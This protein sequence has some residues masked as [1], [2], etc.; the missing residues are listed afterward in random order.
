[1]TIRE[2]THLRMMQQRVVGSDI[3][4]PK[5]MLEWMGALQ[6]QDFSMSKWA[7]GCRLPGLKE[8]DIEES[9]NKG[10]CLRTHAIRPTWHLLSPDNIKWLLKYSA[11]HI[12]NSLKSRYQKLGLTDKIFHKASSI[13]VN[14]LVEK[15]ICL[16]RELIDL[17][18]AQGIDTSM[19]KASYILMDIELK[20]LI[21][22]GP[23]SNK[24]QTYTLLASLECQEFLYSDDNSD[25]EIAKKYF[26]SRGPATVKDFAWWSGLPQRKAKAVVEKITPELDSY[27]VNGQEYWIAKT[28]VETSYVDQQ[29]FLLPAF[30]EMVVA[31]KDRS[32]IIDAEYLPRAVSRNGIIWPIVLLNGQAAGTW[33]R[34]IRKQEVMIE[35]SSFWGLSYSERNQIEEAAHQFAS[36]IDKTPRVYFL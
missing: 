31:Y 13:I 3:S 1:M 9:F 20:G 16:R 14:E 35:V 28:K 36:F 5:L 34:T 11:P 33:K 19:N 2:V 23:L 17:L 22:S 24:K 27:I 6:A 32:A 26:T 8:T 12:R 10:E 7:L 21:C 25:A 15:K 4:N 29:A 30:D 18:E